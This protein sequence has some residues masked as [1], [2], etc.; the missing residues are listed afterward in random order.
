VAATAG[1]DSWVYISGT[2]KLHMPTAEPFD[3]NS[4]SRDSNEQII[5][6]ACRKLILGLYLRFLALMPR[7]LVL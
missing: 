5:L 1:G 7:I 2:L 6:R 4:T 3:R